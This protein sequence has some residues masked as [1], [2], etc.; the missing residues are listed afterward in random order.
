MNI[1]T[2]N[3]HSPAFSIYLLRFLIGGLVA[4]LRGLELAFKGLTVIEM[5]SRVIWGVGVKINSGVDT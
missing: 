5:G 4:A 1:F 3:Y 2:G